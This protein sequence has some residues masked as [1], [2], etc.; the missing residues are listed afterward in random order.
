MDNYILIS[1]LKILCN[2]YDNESGEYP[3][4]RFEGYSLYR[5]IIGELETINQRDEKDDK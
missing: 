2:K 1:D 4:S 3:E 5:F